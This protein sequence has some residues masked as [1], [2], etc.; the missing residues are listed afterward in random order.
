M[1]YRQLAEEFCKL[2][3]LRTRPALDSESLISAY[4]EVGTLFY[5]YHTT[6]KIPAGELGRQ[7]GLTS[8]RNTNLLN[9]LEKKN[10]IRK[11]SDENDKRK[12]FV[13]I[14]DEGRRYIEGKY[15][16]A[17]TRSAELFELLGERDAL[18]YFRLR[19]KVIELVDSE[20]IHG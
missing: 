18:E 13:S 17:V 5:L 16:R 15:Q 6:E 8:G 10:Y 4:G 20:K 3:F 7:R 12:V 9:Y 14:T 19:K 1:D 2:N 11:E